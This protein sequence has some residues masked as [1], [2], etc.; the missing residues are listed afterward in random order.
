MSAIYRSKVLHVPSCSYRTKVLH[1]PLFCCITVNPSCPPTSLSTPRTKEGSFLETGVVCG[2]GKEVCTHMTYTF[3]YK[4]DASTN[5]TNNIVYNNKVCTYRLLFIIVFD[6]CLTTSSISGNCRPDGGLWVM[7]GSVYKQ[8]IHICAHT[9]CVYKPDQ[10]NS[11]ERQYVYIPDQ[12]NCVQKKSVY[13]PPSLTPPQSAPYVS[14]GKALSPEKPVDVVHDIQNCVV[15][16]D[17]HKSHNRS[18]YLC[19]LLLLSSTGKF[20]RYGT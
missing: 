19:L 8:D 14:L 6:L 20:L 4:H 1:V 16:H 18:E 2:Y 9:Q 10:H 17:I 7:K 5:P 15:L 12:Q 3:V 11:V 13:I